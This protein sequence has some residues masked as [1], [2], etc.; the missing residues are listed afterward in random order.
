MVRSDDRE[1]GGSP[2]V[3]VEVV[4]VLVLVEALGQGLGEE[5]RHR[6]QLGPSGQTDM[7]FLPPGECVDRQEVLA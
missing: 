6:L 2:V 7:V 4:F 5:V 3:V 1:A